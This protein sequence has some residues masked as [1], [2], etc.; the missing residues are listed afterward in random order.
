MNRT[1]QDVFGRRHLTIY[2]TIVGQKR[3]TTHQHGTV[4]PKPL[5]LMRDKLSSPWIV[6]E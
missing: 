3:W 5:D 2:D 1:T 6:T 4:P